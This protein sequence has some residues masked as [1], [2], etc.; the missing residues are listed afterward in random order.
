MFLKNVCFKIVVYIRVIVKKN[1]EGKVGRLEEWMVGR[2]DGWK[3]GRLEEWKVGRLE[4]WKVGRLE[5][6]KVGRVEGYMCLMMN[7]CYFCK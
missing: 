1:V 2:V 3:I 6:W 4:G 7:V 5:E